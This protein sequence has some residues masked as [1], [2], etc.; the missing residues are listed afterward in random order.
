VI[1]RRGSLILPDPE[2]GATSCK[3]Y[4]IRVEDYVRLTVDSHIIES[5]LL[6]AECS[7]FMSFRM[8][9]SFM[10][11]IELIGQLIVLSHIAYFPRPTFLAR[12]EASF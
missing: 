9:K 4:F 2:Q 1:D 10:G 7:V 11:T 5:F 3:K 8:Y 6:R 12:P